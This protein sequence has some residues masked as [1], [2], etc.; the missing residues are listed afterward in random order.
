MLR[1][2]LLWLNN[3][4]LNLWWSLG[5]S[6]I[7][8]IPTCVKTTPCIVILGSWL[9]HRCTRSHIKQRAD[10]LLRSLSW[11]RFWDSLRFLGLLR[12]DLLLNLCLCRSDLDISLTLGTWWCTETPFTLLLLLFED[13]LL[14]IVRVFLFLLLLFLSATS[15]RLSWLSLGLFFFT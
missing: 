10:V 5:G 15:L 1:N 7:K 9:L 11:C 8:G 12:L 2:R 13:W 3:W 4:L 14:S 6:R